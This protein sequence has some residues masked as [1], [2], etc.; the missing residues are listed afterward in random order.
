[1]SVGSGLYNYASIMEYGPFTFNKDGVSPTLETIPPGMVLGTSTPQYTTRR[2]GRN[3]APLRAYADRHHRG[4]QSHRIAGRRGQH[5]LHGAVCLHD[6]GQQVPQHT[7]S[8]PTANQTLQTLSGENYI[9]GRWNAGLANCPNRHGYERTRRMAPR[10][11]PPHAPRSP[12]ISPVL[13]PST[14]TVPVINPSG[15]ATITASPLP[16]SSLMVNGAPTYLDRQ[17]ITLTVNPSSGYNF[18]DWY[19]SPFINIYTNPVYRLPD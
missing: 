18:Y 3:H 12:T 4:H 9:F 19:P 16:S 1:M 5:N 11:A 10:C 15:D 8:V 13:F 14:L 7:L 6:L 17:L 2:P